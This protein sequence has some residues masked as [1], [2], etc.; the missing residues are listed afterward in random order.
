[1]PADGGEAIQLTWDGG[2][3][4]LE[5]PDGKFLYYT[6]S[7]GNTTLWRVPLDGG[8]AAKV[9]DG[10]SLYINLAIVDKGIYFVPQNWLSIQFLDLQTNQIKRVAS[11]ERFLEGGL[12]LSPDGQWILYAGGTGTLADQQGGAE[13]RLVENF[14]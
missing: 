11:F 12:A 13:L 9:L 3:A 7:L 14:R 10:L 2:Y 8:Q 1:M 5:S 4:P 6:K